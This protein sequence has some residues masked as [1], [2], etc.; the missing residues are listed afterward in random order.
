MN[1]SSRVPGVTRNSGWQAVDAEIASRAVVPQQTLAPT[2][3]SKECKLSGSPPLHW[4]CS[5]P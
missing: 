5:S 3:R 1:S 4:P 2:L